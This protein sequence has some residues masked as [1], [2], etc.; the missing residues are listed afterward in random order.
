[1]KAKSES[2]NTFE[3][4][5]WGRNSGNESF[6]S[7]LKSDAEI[8]HKSMGC[9]ALKLLIRMINKLDKCVFIH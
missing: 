2:T 5:N 7:M 9:N 6:G 4:E 8:C 1:M 3:K